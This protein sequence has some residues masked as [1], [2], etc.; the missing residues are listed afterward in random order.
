MASYEFNAEVETEVQIDLDITVSDEHGNEIDCDAEGYGTDV[1]VNIDLSDVKENLK[2]SLKEELQEE[3]RQELAEEIGGAMNP[4]KV[5]AEFILLVDNVD[6]LSKERTVNRLKDLG[7]NIRALDIVIVEKDKVI[8][9]L[10]Q[11]VV[12]LGLKQ[13]TTIPSEETE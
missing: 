1:T 8:S 6:R 13:K 9:T 10:T 2:E 7:A 3:F 5:L 11:Q 12:D 4:M